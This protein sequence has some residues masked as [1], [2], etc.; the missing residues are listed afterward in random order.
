MDRAREIL[1]QKFK[2]NKYGP[3]AFLNILA[4]P[5]SE[6]TKFIVEQMILHQ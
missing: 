3:G 4:K 6:A 1:V 2:I 5:T